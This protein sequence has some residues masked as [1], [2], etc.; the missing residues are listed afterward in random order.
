MTENKKVTEKDIIAFIV[1]ISIIALG[2]FIYANFIP[3]PL[4]KEKPISIEAIEI[5]GQEGL[6][7]VSQVLSAL[8]GNIEIKSRT[9]DYNSEEAKK[10][11]ETYNIKTIPALI[12]KSKRINEVQLDPTTFTTNNNAAVFDKAIPY[13]DISS[14]EVKGQV[15]LTEVYDSSC[16]DCSSLSQYEKQ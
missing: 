5:T 2:F 15:E 11:I 1:I 16:K 7:D 10:L 14:G 12:L 6:F 13:L 8:S 3:K 4:F 9:L